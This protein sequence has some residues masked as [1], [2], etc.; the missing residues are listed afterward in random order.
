MHRL[1]VRQLR[2]SLG[3]A[4]EEETLALIKELDRVDPDQIPPS[5]RGL[6]AALPDMF[7]RIG[8]TY[9]Q[10]DRDLTLRNRSLE[11]SSTELT[12][13]NAKLRE[14]A[15]GQK[16]A[17]DSLRRTANEI[18]ASMSRDE[19]PDGDVGLEGLS[20][21][22]AS[23]VG[24]HGAMQRELAQQKFALDQ[25]AIVSITD[26][27]GLILYAN[28]KFCE[29][30]EYSTEELI[31]QNHRLVNSGI[32]SPDMFDV[33]WKT[34]T[35]GQ[36][37][38]GEICNRKKNGGQY[39]VSATIVPIVDEQGMPRQYIGI[40]TDITERKAMEEA[41]RESE[42]RL[43]IALEAGEIGLWTWN[44]QTDK[45]VF[46]PQWMTMLG[47][48]THDLPHC[49]D[50][51][52][53][54]L[55]PEDTSAV[56]RALEA[57]FSGRA[58]AYEVEF[59]LQHKNGGWRWILAAGR[60][61]DLDSEGR[62][63][64][65]AG[66][67]KDITDR[68]VV[69]DLL[70]EAVEK[71]ES[72]S[73]AKSDFLAT[74]SHEIRTPMNGIIGMTSLLMD[75]PLNDEQSHFAVTVRNSAEALL[76]IINDILDFSKLEAGRLEFEETSFE[77]RPLVEGVVDLLSP[78][79]RGRSIDLS[80]L[81][82]NEARGVF[83]GDPGR[84][85]QVLLNL[86]GNA[87]KFTQRGGVS[88]IVS[89]LAGEGAEP[90]LRVKVI[91]T[92]IGIPESARPRIFGTFS[93][94]DSSIGRRYGGS[95]LGLA[96][97]KR[98]VD[99]MGGKIGFET[100]EGKG[101][102][103]WFEVPL[104]R[105]DEE[106]FEDICENPLLD[107][108]ILVV[109]DNPINR[110]IFQ[111]QLEGWGARVITVES[112][113]LGL[114]EVR[115]AQAKEMPFDLVILDHLMPGM[116]GLDLA[117]VLR[118]DPASSAMPLVMASSAD[119]ASLKPAVQALNINHL[120][121]KPVRQSAL[122]DVLMLVLGRGTRPKRIAD[123]A[124]KSPVSA[125]PLRILVAED[126]AVNQQVAVGL[127]TKLGHRA[128]V[129]DDGSEAVDLVMKG[130]YD[131]V[132]MDMQMPNVDGLAATA[133]IRALPGQQSKVAIIAMT[134]NAMAGDRDLC[135]SGGMDD[136]ISKP[137]DRRRLGD[138]LGR[139]NSRLIDARSGRGNNV[140]PPISAEPALPREDPAPVPLIDIEA[141][142]DLCETLGEES[143]AALVASFRNSLTMRIAQIHTA[144][145]VGDAKAAGAA[146]HSVKGAAS[147]LAFSRLARAAGAIE[148]AALQGDS[149]TMELVA[150][151]QSAADETFAD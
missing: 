23:L 92:G 14:E 133:L 12:R 97:S 54:L 67:H 11:L 105:S 17:M 33:M 141:Q 59:R 15:A 72:A 107:A 143:F 26:A 45:A 21:L 62:P 109:D 91:D 149:V 137:V 22:M 96:I 151:L 34:I 100:E 74:M 56:Q 46:S 116:S 117:A 138:L 115:A 4:T 66:I 148:M 5:L 93:Q 78:R 84:L 98:I 52:R 36:V 24:D 120:L 103:F 145:S 68:K 131:L 63:L 150:A 51:W 104:L 9:D 35:S 147:N 86:A 38:H 110:E 121:S 140:M 64:R 31:G 142:Q 65:M 119:I 7:Q 3:G 10:H 126:N 82:P 135:L 111:Y 20:D 13:A 8:E 83:R 53:R 27:N 101:S 30:S 41:L 37:W 40:R 108:R 112:A 2:R 85:R 28:K 25:H 130:D 94:A 50:T 102:T 61:I 16:R 44:T 55:H 32:H 73:R 125:M 18:L 127:L 88:V 132:L 99:A 71:A 134:A 69:E 29:I 114:M 144:T 124:E 128:D 42:Q 43:Q 80:Y 136:Y 122:L 77:I 49:G 6:V 39:W 123:I 90:I 87:L 47:Y 75:T 76:G 89:L 70:V 81:V 58:A 95:G 113:A 129:A 60:L 48:E 79:I 146:A 106:P 118:S 19:L 57:H 1:L 139:W